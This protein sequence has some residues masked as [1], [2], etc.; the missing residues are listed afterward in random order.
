MVNQSNGIGPQGSDPLKRT[1]ASGAAGA[2]AKSKKEGSGVAFRALLDSLQV[3]A[4][5]L[6]EQS[7]AVDRP[8]DLSEAVGQARETLEEALDVHDRLLEAFRQARQQ[9]GSGPEGPAE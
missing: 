1:D 5:E 2:S 7:E 9:S 6:S 8:A 4:T 3:R